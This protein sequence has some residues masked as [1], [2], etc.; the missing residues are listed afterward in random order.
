MPE[1]LTRERL[2][3]L[4]EFDETINRFSR[5]ERTGDKKFNNQFAGKLAGA[6][7]HRG[8][9]TYRRIKIGGKSYFEHRLVWLYYYGH[10]PTEKLDHEDGDGL[11]NSRENLRLAPGNFNHKSKAKADNNTSGYTN[12]S[13]NK[14]K[15]KWRVKVKHNGI[16]HHGGL[17]KEEDLQ[18]AIAKAQ[19]MREAFGFSPTHG[20]TREERKAPTST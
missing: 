15:N 16:T 11:N 3:E 12:V 19:E 13:W 4:L 6:E 9:L 17:F 5:K 20:L 8:Q 18:L 1:T 14:Q 7:W 2:V 10:F